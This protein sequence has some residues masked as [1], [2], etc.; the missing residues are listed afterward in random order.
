MGLPLSILWGNTLEEWVILAHNDFPGIVGDEL[1]WY[2]LLRLNSVPRRLLA[3]QTTPRDRH[4]A[5]L[6]RLEPIL[7][8][9]MPGVADTI[10]TVIDEMTHATKFKLVNWLHTE[11]A[12]LTNEDLNFSIDKPENR[13]NIHLVSYH[14]LLSRAK[15][16]C[17]GQLSYCA[18]SFRIFHESH[19]STTTN[20]VGLQIAMN[21][22]VGFKLQVTTTPG[23]NSI[24]DGCYQMMWLFRGVHDD[25]E[26]DTETE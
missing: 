9:T 2:P 25:T 11:N 7:V 20:C 21:A 23:F 13:W 10:K 22:Q 1:D 17:N 4:P 26:D 3:I 18:W 14:T 19:W 15:P 12:N 16:S 5:L 24:W 8:V 6:S